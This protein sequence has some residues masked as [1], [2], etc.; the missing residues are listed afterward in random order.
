MISPMRIWTIAS[1]TVREAIRSK[2]LYTLLMFA[3]VMIG[4]S[5][6]VSSLS[7]VEPERIMQDIAL[8]AIRLFSVGIA[9]F[10]GVGLIHG[11]IE[12]RT[13]YT[14]LSKPVSRSEF[15]LGKYLGLVLT[16]WMQLA[17]MSFA[18][19]AL[20]MG[21][22][23]VVDS[24]HAAAL[25]L[26]GVEL[27]LLVAVATLFSSFTTP[28]LASFFSCGVWVLG[29]L[30]RNLRDHASQ[31]AEVFVREGAVWMHR[32]LPDLE[33]FNL[34]KEASHLLPLT[35]SEVWYPVLYGLGYVAALLVLATSIFE[36]R[37]FR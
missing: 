19:V 28:M 29:H 9:I 4:T 16:V 6:I 32:I 20:S 8:A 15:L 5:S 34:S 37:D 27:M 22:E 11:E 17:I 36:R 2:I 10:L 13:I 3:V 30:T 23:A 12:R 14:I 24:G 18:F 25:G 31:S 26:I 21:T 33:S 7:Y 35:A 1:N